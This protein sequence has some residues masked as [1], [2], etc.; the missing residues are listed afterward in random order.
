MYGCT[1]WMQTK[2][3]EKHKMGTTQECYE[4][5]WTNP[6]SSNP[7]KQQMYCYLPPIL[8]TIR[9]R[10]T[11]HAGHSRRSKDELISNILLWTS[12]HGRA[13]VDRLARTYIHRLCANT[14]CSLEDPPGAIDDRDEWQERTEGNM[15]CQHDLIMVMNIDISYKRSITLIFTRS[16]EIIILIIMV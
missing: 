7:I 1:T 10:Q 5:F 8:K 11:R 2:C 14:R 12:T 6:G 4:L 13:S 15:C 9:V 3:I 16:Q